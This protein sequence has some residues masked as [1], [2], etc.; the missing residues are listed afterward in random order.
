MPELSILFSLFGFDG[1]F[2]VLG[3]PLSLVPL[4][5]TCT[6][7]HMAVAS[8][9]DSGMLVSHAIYPPGIV[10]MTFLGASCIRPLAQSWTS[11]FGFRAADTV[12]FIAE[13]LRALN[14]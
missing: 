6:G 12:R 8:V 3:S 7:C 10:T 13:N 2:G 4:E 5:V 14:C 9:T 11:G 1:A